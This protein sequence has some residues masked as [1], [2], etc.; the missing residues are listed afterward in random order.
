MKARYDFVPTTPVQVEL[1]AKREQFAERTSGLPNI[2]IDGV[3]FGRVRR[4]HDP[5]AP[6]RYNWG[7]VLWHELG[8]VFAIQLSKNHVPRWF[9]EGL[10]EYETIARRPEWKRELDPD[11]YM[12]LTE[13]R[14]P[15][16]ADMNH[17]FTHATDVSD[18]GVA[19]YASSQMLVFTVEQFGMP[20]VVDA[21]KL[22]GQGVR[23]PD[24]IQRAFGL[25]AGDYDARY[26]AWEMQKLARYKGQ[27]MFRERAIPLDD[28]K[29]KVAAAPNDAKAHVELAMALLHG[30]KAQDAKMELDTA[31]RLDPDEHDRALRRCE[32]LGGR[33]RR[34]PRCTSTRSRAPGGTAIRSRWGSPRSPRSAKDATAMPRRRSKPHTAST[35]RRSRPWRGS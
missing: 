1:Y 30:P 6:R 21:L 9:T 33:P 28:A 3:C 11:L 29:A 31:L 7:N 18:I 16:A 5:R 27:F 32:A 13:N 10:S 25:S 23:T 24:V 34:S 26:R 35:R 12:A 20:K 8:H 15:S 17:A 14:L 4:G 19:Y 22:W 2:G